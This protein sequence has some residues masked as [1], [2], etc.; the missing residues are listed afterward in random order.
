MLLFTWSRWLPIEEAGKLEVG[1]F[2]DSL[3]PARRGRNS[4]LHVPSSGSGSCR[5]QDS[6]SL[7]IHHAVGGLVGS[8]P[9][10][11]LIELGGGMTPPRG[12]YVQLHSG[13]RASAGDC[14]E[15]TGHYPCKRGRV[16]T[17]LKADI[18]AFLQKVMNLMSPTFRSRSAPS[19]GSVG[20]GHHPNSQRRGKDGLAR[21]SHCKATRRSKAALLDG[22]GLDREAARPILLTLTHDVC[23]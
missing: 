7:A 2:G 19:A 14:P 4:V 13:R 10:D 3:R 18:P 15:T 9:T 1:G 5:P 8:L 16:P 17:I 23:Y 20:G 12:L 22:G 6:M 21:A 11:F